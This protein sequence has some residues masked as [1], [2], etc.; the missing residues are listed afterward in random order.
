MHIR[1]NGAYQG[2][3][4]GG[5]TMK[6]PSELANVII[7]RR[8]QYSRYH[9]LNQSQYRKSKM[10]LPRKGVEKLKIYGTHDIY[11]Y[12]KSQIENIYHDNV[13]MGTHEKVQTF[14]TALGLIKVDPTSNRLFDGG[15]YL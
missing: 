3:E 8:T 1:A 12:S 4:N 9:I 14:R 5:K 10:K 13:V 15:Q 6:I 11:I 7:K 2:V